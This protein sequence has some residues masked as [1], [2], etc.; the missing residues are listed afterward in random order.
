MV[1]SFRGWT[2]RDGGGKRE[3]HFGIRLECPQP[4]NADQT[5]VSVKPNRTLWGSRPWKPFCV[6]YFLSIENRLHSASVTFPVGRFKQWLKEK[7]RG[8][9]SDKEGA[10]KEPQRA[11]AGRVL[12]PPQGIH[13][14]I[15]FELFCRYWNPL[16]V[17]TVNCVMPTS[18]RPQMLWDKEVD[19]ADSSELPPH[20]AVRR[21]SMS[22]LHPPLCTITIKLLTPT[23]R[24]RHSFEGISPLSPL[25]LAKQWSYPFLMNLWDLIW[26]WGSE[27]A[28]SFTFPTQPSLHAPNSP[29]TS[30]TLLPNIWRLVSEYLC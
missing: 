11:L 15:I 29:F 18:T 30:Q 5:R 6:P 2:R 25:C 17:G 23:S 8:T 4:S 3:K 20:Q 26:C 13:R 19:D 22:S 9:C 10:V 28:F 12:L 27:I 21:I 14:N 7:G 1:G 16:Q 24:L